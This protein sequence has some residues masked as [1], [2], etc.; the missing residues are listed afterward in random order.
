MKTQHFM[1]SLCWYG[2]QGGALK[3]D[4]RGVIFAAQ[5]LTLPDKLK[6]IKMPYNSIKLAVCRCALGFPAVE[7]T[8]DSGAEYKFIV[9]GRERLLR[10]LECHRV[11]VVRS[12]NI[13]GKFKING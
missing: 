12:A 9:F 8:L 11:M 10:I 6:K 7:I 13:I 5:K 2:A 3:A 1:A 4:D